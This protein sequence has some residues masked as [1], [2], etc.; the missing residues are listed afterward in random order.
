MN[1][2]KRTTTKGRNGGRRSILGLGKAAFAAAILVA[3][4]A[5]ADCKSSQITTDPAVLT[6]DWQAQ[7]VNLIAR[8][9]QEGMPWSCV[10]GTLLVRLSDGGGAVLRF[11]DLDGQEVERRVPSLRL[12]VPTAEALLARAT[13][14][15]KSHD[16]APVAALDEVE[17]ALELP[18]P[19]R[20]EPS[21]ASTRSPL[22]PRYIVD[23][24]LGV[25]FSGPAAAVWIAPQLRAIVP[26]DAWSIG[27]W[28][29]Y[30]I[31][32]VFDV[33]SKNFAMSQGN[34]GFSAGRQ[35]LSAPVDVRLTFTPSLSVTSMDADLPDHE[36][37][38]ARID[39]YLGA[40]LSAAIPFAQSWCGLVA[41]DAEIVPAALR[42]ERRI[43]PGLPAL[44]AYELGVSLGVELVAR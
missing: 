15:E 7:V 33:E 22:E 44:P 39:M 13:P 2:D 18:P 40:G 32:Y 34:L 41:L 3:G 31:P 19:D 37:S 35:L 28:I 29:R 24:A 17:H 16:H 1:R 8:T 42:K 11:R 21:R 20:M 10:G 25:R 27:V 36:A 23:A 30:G 4:S 12:L 38:G 5:R 9:Q 6:A 43:D 26:I 14:R